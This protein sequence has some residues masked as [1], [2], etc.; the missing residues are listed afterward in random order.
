M[1]GIQNPK[2][3]SCLKDD[4]GSLECVGNPFWEESANS[5]TLATKVMISA[6]GMKA[7][8]ETEAMGIELSYNSTKS[9]RKNQM[10][11]DVWKQ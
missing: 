6:E 8:K 11:V 7:A 5:I 4:I 2:Y 3:F 9:R 1:N 10:R